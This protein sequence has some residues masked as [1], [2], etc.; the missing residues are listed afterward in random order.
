MS[1]NLS[2]NFLKIKKIMKRN[3]L[4]SMVFF[5]F[6][7]SNHLHAQSSEPMWLVQPIL[8]YD[9]LGNFSESLAWVKSNPWSVC[10]RPRRK[11]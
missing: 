6:L 3:L 9:N 4:I 7:F 2:S 1:L 8:E 5:A 10:H 11:E